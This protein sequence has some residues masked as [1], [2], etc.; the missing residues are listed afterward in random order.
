MGLCHHQQLDQQGKRAT[1]QERWEEARLAPLKH[2][3]AGG[4]LL[5]AGGVECF[6]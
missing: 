1:G 5:V 3:P 2:L 4:T 6:G